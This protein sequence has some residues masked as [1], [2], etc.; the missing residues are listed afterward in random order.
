MQQIAQL[1][2]TMAVMGSSRTEEKMGSDSKDSGAP[3]DALIQ[4]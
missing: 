3:N 1:Q 4:L 2:Q